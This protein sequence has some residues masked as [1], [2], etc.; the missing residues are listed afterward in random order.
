MGVPDFEALASAGI[1][2]LR[3]Y[4]P[5]HDIVALRRRFP[6]GALVELGSNENPY[7]PSQRALDA[8]LGTLPE[9]HRYPDPL[10]ADLKQAIADHLRLEPSQVFLGN[11]SHELLMMLAQA[12]AGPGAGVVGS[13]FGFAVYAIAAQAAGAKYAKAPALTV[14]DSMPRGHDLAAIEAA[15]VASTRMVYLANPNNPTGTWFSTVALDDFLSRL[16]SD[17]LVIVDEAYLEYVTDPALVSAVSLLPKYP[18]LVVTRT[19]SKAYGLAG[20]RVGYACAHVGLLRVL[21]RVRESFNV[22]APGLAACMAAL[23]DHA[24][25][26][27]VVRD[28]AAERDWLAARLRDRGLGIGPS[29]TNFLLIEFDREA[30]PFESELISRGVVL[31]PMVGYGLPTCLRATVGTRSENERLLQSLDQVLA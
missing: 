2:K 12:F 3:A 24:H 21:D 31:R 7:G 19:F 11:G 20:L 26:Q 9:L 23:A 28:N 14:L 10:A 6:G 8:L 15:V 18:N 25:L 16:R 27:S 1:Q 17:T 13:E 30:A 5:G 4:D 29:Q 22:N